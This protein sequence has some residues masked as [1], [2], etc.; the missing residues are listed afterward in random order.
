MT[1]KIFVLAMLLLCVNVVSA[2][3]FK[4]KITKSFQFEKK[5]AANAIMVFNING[6]VDVEG[7]TG[8]QVIVE[9]EKTITG[10]TQA[11]VDEGK[12]DIQLGVI[13]A[14]DSLIFYIKGTG[15]EFSKSSTR[16]NRSEGW[17]YRWNDHNGNWDRNY[18]YTM[19][20]KI[21]I[22]MNVH[23]MASTINDGDVAITNT[24][25]EVIAKNING[26]IRL[27]QIT[28]KTN[29]NTI[30]GNVDIDYLKNPGGDSR[31]Y[32]LNGDI[33]VNFPTSLSA[34]MSFKS[35]NGD[36]YTNIEPLETLPAIVNKTETQKGIKF[37]VETDRFKIRAGGPLL[38]VETFNGD[39]FIKEV[40]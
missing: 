26:H 15:A 6:D 34:T 13:D 1:S 4:E 31:Y 28:G 10:K 22:P 35:F 32:T 14:A 33:H 37:K 16:R 27:K 23:V 9:V 21:K 40:K 36:L 24:R 3:T 5:S 7:T 29:A 12:E 38:D 25:G 19:H 8:D 30:N 18:E 20:F 11:R 2:Q 17:G 39:A